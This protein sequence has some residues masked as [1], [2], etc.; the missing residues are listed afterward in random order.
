ML[1]RSHGGSLCTFNS[2]RMSNADHIG[3]HVNSPVLGAAHRH[4]P[5]GHPPQA[6]VRL[7]ATG[8]RRHE[9]GALRGPLYLLIR[10]SG[11][12]FALAPLAATLPAPLEAL[13]KSCEKRGQIR[14]L[15]RRQV[16]LK[17]LVVE[18]HDL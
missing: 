2:S 6:R 7:T 11:G 16:H 10:I 17:P 15:L 3:T 12:C 9:L 18:A 8:L 14:F 5:G 13:L 4:D 1:L